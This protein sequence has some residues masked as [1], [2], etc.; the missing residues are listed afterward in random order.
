MATFAPGVY[1]IQNLGT[2]TVLDLTNGSTS[3]DTPV[4]GWEKRQLN[5]PWVPAQLWIIAPVGNNPA[6]TVENATGRTFLD[7]KAGAS[8]NGTPVVGNASSGGASQ[9]WVFTASNSNKS[10]FIISN[11]STNTVVDL[12]DGNKANGATVQA[13]ANDGAATTNPN[14]LWHVTRV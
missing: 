13:W 14:Q 4:Q 11:A 7:V 10:A 9:H 6:C 5:D 1:Y 2:N 12:K 8:A 3:N